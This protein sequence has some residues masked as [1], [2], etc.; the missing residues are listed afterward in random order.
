MSVDAAAD[1]QHP[2]DLR[3][4]QRAIDAGALGTKAVRPNPRVGCALVRGDVLLGLGFHQ[5]CG[6]PHAEVEALRAA[7]TALGPDAARGATAYVTLEPCNHHGRTPPCVDA[8]LAA[9]VVRVVVAVRDPH[10]VAGGGLERLRAAGVAV[11]AGPGAEAAAILIE[12]F[13]VGVREQR[14]FLRLKMAASLDGQTAA[15][16]GTSRWL[17][18]PAARARVHAMRAEADAVLVGS[19]TVLAD[20]PRLDA[21]GAEVAPGDPPLRVVVDRRLRTPPQAAVC[22]PAL[23]PTRLYTSGEGARSAQA[24]A[25][26]QRGVEVV[27]IDEAVGPSRGAADR[28]GAA[29]AVAA[30]GTGGWLRAVLCD[31]R[32]RGQHEVL[33]EGG[34]TLAAGLW[35]QGLVDRLELMLAPMLL[36]SG[37]G[38]WP[39][40]GVGTLGEALRLQVDAVHRLG[41]DLHVSARPR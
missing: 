5:R 26:R 8:L 2:D 24:E 3:W 35:R 7:A 23:G 4:M 40:I 39:H 21:R 6:G 20:D 18:G 38:L 10:P 29:P 1:G 27:G 16:D 12:G 25:L 17:T 30:D 22:D 37:A 31:L 13:V 11:V 9:G 33:C 41:P 14:A 34:A 28:E 32:Q 15:S 36:G 19:G